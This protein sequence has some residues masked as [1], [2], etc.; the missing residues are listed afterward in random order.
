MRLWQTVDS[1]VR[2]LVEFFHQVS[3]GLDFL[4]GGDNMLGLPC[5]LLSSFLQLFG[6]HLGAKILLYACQPVLSLPFFGDITK[7]LWINCTFLPQA[8]SNKSPRGSISKRLFA[9]VCYIW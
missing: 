3:E 2:C 6:I 5:L 1:Q 7:E 4:S 8:P 9:V